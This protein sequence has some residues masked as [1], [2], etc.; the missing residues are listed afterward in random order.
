MSLA[1]R[2][3]TQRTFIYEITADMG[4]LNMSGSGIIL[5]GNVMSRVNLGVV[6][7]SLTGV[8]SRL[9]FSSCCSCELKNHSFKIN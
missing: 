6:L 7:V 5:G 9:L 3:T 2:K 1:A 4:I 8:A